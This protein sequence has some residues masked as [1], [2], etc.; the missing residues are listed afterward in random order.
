MPVLDLLAQPSP[1]SRLPGADAAAPAA[2]A[3]SLPAP[4]VPPSGAPAAAGPCAPTGPAAA[5]PALPPPDSLTLE[6]HSLQALLELSQEI[7]TTGDPYRVA[8]LGL[9]KL[10]GHLGTSA[11]ALWVFSKQTGRPVLLRSLGVPERTAAAL[12]DICVSRLVADHAG[13][14]EPVFV[15][16]LS[17]ALTAAESSLAHAAR[18]SLFGLLFSSGKPVGAV[19]LGRRVTGTAYAPGQLRILQASLHHLGVALENT[20]LYAS[21]LDQNRE[22]RQARA[23]LQELDGLK[24]QFLDSLQHELRTPLS[25]ILSYAEILRGGRLAAA[26]SAPLLDGLHEQA[27]RLHTLIENLL[28]FSDLRAERVQV[29]VVSQDVAAFL[30]D[31][32]QERRPGLAKD[33]R[34]MTLS[35]EDSLPPARCDLVR[36]RQILD[37]LV[38]NASKFTPQGSRISLRAA[39]ERRADGV[40]ARLE[41]ADDGPGVPAARVAAAFEPFRQLDGGLAREAGGVGLGLSL[42]RELARSMGGSLD[43]ASAEGRGTTCVLRLPAG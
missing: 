2:A 39:A 43:I 41:L 19:A 23:R 28:T 20:L 15:D 6:G 9:L 16:D 27:V 1:A 3:A 17:T 7:H 24:Q 12:G 35:L 30:R 11:A 31:Y 10:M 22:L 32:F 37:E 14:A 18:I 26:E 25:V 4:G 8:E 42:A 36:L 38:A 13:G 33:L 21:I 5:P 40:W 34:E 29:A